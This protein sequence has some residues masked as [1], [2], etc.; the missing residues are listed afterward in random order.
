M[1]VERSTLLYLFGETD[2]GLGLHMKN[3][4][5]KTHARLGA[6]RRELVENW[7]MCIG[8]KPRVERRSQVVG[9]PP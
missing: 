9:F 8:K 6:P 7:A 1:L 4:A 3:Q 2:S 5:V